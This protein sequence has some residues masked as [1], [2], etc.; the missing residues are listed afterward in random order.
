MLPSFD[1]SEPVPFLP[2]VFGLAIHNWTLAICMLRATQHWQ[3]PW[4][5]QMDGVNEAWGSCFGRIDRLMIGAHLF[6][7][8]RS[9]KLW[10]MKG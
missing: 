10:A 5:P 8:I 1:W 9:P 6:T 7:V 4:L 3:C 2:F